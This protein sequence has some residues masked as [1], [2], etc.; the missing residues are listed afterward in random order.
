MDF[1]D[2]ALEIRQ[3]HFWH[4]LSVKE[5]TNS[6]RFEGGGHRPNLSMGAGVKTCVAILKN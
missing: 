1:Y 4:N 6:A 3:Q 2:L 5:F